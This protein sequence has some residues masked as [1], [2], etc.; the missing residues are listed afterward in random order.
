MKVLWIGLGV[1][2][3]LGMMGMAAQ[4]PALPEIKTMPPS[5]PYVWRNVVIRG[6]GFVSGLVFSTTEKGLVYARTDVGGAYRSEDAG[7]HWVPLTDRFGREEATYLG[8]ESIALDPEDGNKL[9]IA[10]GM[11]A[12]DWGGPA[13][14]FRSSDRGKT[15]EKTAMPFKMGGNDNGRGC[16][17][18]LAVDPNLGSVLYFGSRKAGLWRSVDSGVTWSHVESFPVKTQVTGPGAGTGITF[19]AFDGSTGSKGAA[20]KTIYAGVAQVGI[21][22]YRSQDAG[23]TWELMPGA[24]KGLF[25]SHA[26]VDPGNAV[27]FSY[28][29]N[30]GP[31]GIQDGAIWKL[32]PR[33]GK[34]KDVSPIQPVTAGMAKFGFGGIGMDR[35]HPETVMVTTIDRWGAGDTIFRTTDG[36]KK[37]K[38]LVGTAQYSAVSTPW[39]YWHKETTGG[40]GW[41]SDIEIDPFDPGKVLYTTGEG[42]WGSADVTAMDAGKPTH[43]GFPNEGLEETVP[44]GIVSPPEGAHLLSAIGDIGGFR[45]EDIAKSPENG[46]FEDPRLTSG[47]SIDFAGLAPMVV[48]R[49]GYGDAKV[50]RGGYSL[51]NGV[52]WK[53]FASEPP[54][55]QK[56]GGAVAISADGKTVVWSP[57]KGAPFWTGDWGKNW[58]PCKGLTETM[59]AV[60]DR[61]NPEKFYSFNTETGQL[62]ESVDGAKTFSLRTA[63]VAPKGNYAMIAPVPGS[64]G[65]LW[66]GAG[67]RVFHSA[68][69][70]VTF[71]TLEG[72]VDAYKIGFGMAAPGRSAAAVYINGTVQKME[73]TFRSEDEGRSWVRVDD[74]DHQFGWKNAVAG[75]P[76]V[77]GRVYLATGGRGVVYGEPARQ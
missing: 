16:G 29:D 63:P 6:G 40:H 60:S 35:E 11:Y 45:H 30:I 21:G 28:V 39:V 25:P 38:D 33:D 68:D 53:P 44:D 51:D 75:D 69:S 61:V 49:V 67:K 17:E 74:A 54:S 43:W 13:A 46:F 14:I 9:Y 18:R 32:T 48:V 2:I 4:T 58:S 27:Y 10:E 52:T 77:Y 1:G 12:A 66:I 24:P 23:A 71:V 19:V 47:S 41:M 59:R 36:G 26:A 65:D 37:W 42:I 70:G 72:M 50:A 20:T 56:G 8:I 15:F 34:W 55:S 3:G 62:L 5:V 22:L 31:N 73:G 64:E 57:G 76:R 7:N